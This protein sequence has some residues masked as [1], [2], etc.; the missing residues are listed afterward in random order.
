M[1]IPRSLDPRGQLHQ[2]AVT[3]T[4]MVVERS[5]GGGETFVAA[6]RL[7]IEEDG[8]RRV[9]AF[10]WLL[11]DAEVVHEFLDGWRGALDLLLHFGGP[12]AGCE[13]RGLA[14]LVGCPSEL[15][16]MIGFL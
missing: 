11:P 1:P 9:V 4:D 15:A 16:C 13:G 8:E 2:P 6:G 10:L 12:S 3:S 7:V 5:L 14:V